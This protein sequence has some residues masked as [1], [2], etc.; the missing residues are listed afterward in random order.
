MCLGFVH[1]QYTCEMGFIT[2]SLYIEKDNTF[3][4]SDGLKTP[5][6]KNEGQVKLFKTGN[7]YYLMIICRTN[8][9]FDLIGDLEIKSG[10]KSMAPK[11]IKQH[12]LN[13]RTA[14]F[15][16]EVFKNY[17]ATLKDGGIT[18]IVFNNTETTFG[19]QDVKEIKKISNCFYQT[20]NVPNA[21]K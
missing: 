16:I 7:K 15:V 6:L 1:A 5:L 3:I 14:F 4:Q 8:L 11:G 9:Y 12:Q 19:K 10:D 21:K 13:K 2:D 20:I 18:S 17:I